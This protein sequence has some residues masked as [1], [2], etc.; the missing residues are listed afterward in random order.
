MLLQGDVDQRL[1][2]RQCALVL[3]AL[4]Q[5]FVLS[6]NHPVPEVKR[7]DE[8]V[9]EI[10]AI[11]LNPIDWKSVDFG[12][13]IPTLPYVA[14]RDFAG[15][16]VK[17][18]AAPSHIQLGDVVLCASTDY[19]DQRKAAYQQYAIASQHTV[20]RLP[21]HV[22]I[23][24]GAALG[25]A[26]IAASLALGVCLGVKLPKAG[27]GKGVA[28]PDIRRI[29]RR[30]RLEDLPPDQVAE[31]LAMDE[32]DLPKSGEWM[33]IWGGSST[34]A[35]FLSQLAGLAGLKVILVVDVAKHGARMVESNGM[36]LIDSHNTDRASQIIRGATGGKLRL[37]IDTVGKPTAEAL[38][39]CLRPDGDRK[40]HIVGLA[41]LPKERLPGVVYHSVPVKLFHEVPEVGSSLMGWLEQALQNDVLSLPAVETAPGGLEG[42]NAALDRMRQGQISGKRLVV[43]L[44]S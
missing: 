14:G 32:K 16:V 41:A 21:G 43:P 30:Q 22:P 34:S 44:I 11:G 17:A 3:H 15:V 27:S 37:G 39:K 26:Y 29:V 1:P 25:V 38:A 33:V 35:L 7:P 23:P 13:G 18:P 40:A 9:V 36:L 20:C 42:V 28:S 19:R 12:Y 8:L 4:K 2:A 5:R 31:C 24:Q 6:Q 10:R